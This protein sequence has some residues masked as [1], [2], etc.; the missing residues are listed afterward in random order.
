MRLP[1]QITL[2]GMGP[3]EAIGAHIR[4]RIDQLDR[5]HGRV[6]S[7]RVVVEAAHRHQRKGRIY[8][9]SLDI[10]VPG[11]EIAVRR[12][13]PE[14]H[15]HEDINVAIRDAFDAAERR[16]DDLRRRDRGQTEVHEPSAYRSEE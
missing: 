14:H 4:R 9:L 8:H 10:K 3:S 13:P 12:D 11:H 15:A 2:R 5:F 6:M 16:L 7:C 1:P